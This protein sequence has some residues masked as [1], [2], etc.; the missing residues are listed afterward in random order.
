[1]EPPISA[2]NEIDGWEY[3]QFPAIFNSAGAVAR[4]GEF[5]VA[6]GRRGS[7]FRNHRKDVALLP[8]QCAA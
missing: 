8:I 2:V 7:G 1:L 3:Y 4:S 5:A 6:A